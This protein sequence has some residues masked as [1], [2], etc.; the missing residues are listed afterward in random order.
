MYHPTS[1]Y[2][3]LL[4]EVTELQAM[5]RGEHEDLREATA[6]GLTAVDLETYSDAMREVAAREAQIQANWF[7]HAVK[8]MIG[9][10]TTTPCLMVWPKRGEPTILTEDPR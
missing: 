2:G 1:L 10:L 5:Y 9:T 6:R 3:P 4:Q 8:V 7:P